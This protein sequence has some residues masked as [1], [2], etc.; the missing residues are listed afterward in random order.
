MTFLH[1]RGADDRLRRE[2]LE[3]A[4]AAAAPS[5]P[6]S[7]SP[8]RNAPM[9][10]PRRIGVVGYGAG[11]RWFHV[12]YILAVP[13]WELV[14]VVTRSADR[15]ALL[16]EEAPGVAAFDSLDELIDA[17]V[18]AVVIT[19]PPQTRRELVL[20]ALERGVN[21]VADKPFAPDAAGAR[22]LA[23]VAAESGV[24]LTVFHNRRWDTDVRTLADVI[25]R[26]ELG[27]IWR[28]T[29]RFDLDDPA[30][31]EAG[32]AHG[33]LRDVGS[34]LVDQMIALFGPVA[35][36]DSHLDMTSID[37][38][39]VDCGFVVTLH[40]RGGVTSTVSSSKLNHLHEREIIAYGSQGA[41]VSRMSDV[42]TRQIWAGLRPATTTIG[43]GVEDRERW[44]TLHAGGG[45][46]SVPSAAGDYT[47][48]YR[49]LLRA[50]RGEGGLPVTLES[51]VHTVEVLDA[52]RQ[53]ATEGRTIQ[54][55]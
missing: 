27:E 47:E 21:T 31:L 1:I 53:S 22:E 51:A 50:V 34:H 43:W 35:R 39:E 19:T 6:L 32:P 33:L 16:A 41:Y 30:T 8:D 17:G 24:L 9:T 54:F 28:V 52:A 12:P 25:S 4:P 20:R 49:G 18:D 46:T 10:D 11:G 7:M 2:G 26:G 42:Q 40:H 37:G 15:R 14:G 5:S 3:D 36:V 38:T 23:A 44:G 13:D 29:S 55:D 48:F 45:V